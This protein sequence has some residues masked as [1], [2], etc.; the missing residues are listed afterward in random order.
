MYIL[1]YGSGVHEDCGHAYE[2]FK[3]IIITP[4]WTEE[5]CQSLVKV[6]EIYKNEFSTGIQWNGDSN[7]TL[8]WE[9]ITLESLS[10]VLFEEFV[11]Q[12]KRS[13]LPLLSS[14]FSEP[15]TDIPGWFSPYI[16]RYTEKGQYVDLHNDVSTFTLNIKLN[17]DYQGCDLVFPRQNFNCKDVPIGHAIIWPSTV[18]HP[19]MSTP[20]EH[21]TKYSI[22]SWTWPQFWQKEGIE[23][24]K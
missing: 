24:L 6:A 13:I 2:N 22:V 23:F 1:N 16:I 7:R 12:Y 18:T 15:S 17:N 19:H 11:E 10:P 3:D 8:G 20:L 5:F 14:I 21:G 4:F 9:D